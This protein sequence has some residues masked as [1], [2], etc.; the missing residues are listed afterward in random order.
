MVD[1]YF[2]VKVNRISPEFPMPIMTGNTGTPV[3]RPGG[4]ANVAYQFRHFNVDPI[5]F[6]FWDKYATDV[7]KSHDIKVDSAWGTQCC[8]PIKRR[9]LDGPVQITRHDIE[10]ELCGYTSHEAEDNLSNFKSA[11]LGQPKPHVAI[12]SDYNKGFFRFPAITARFLDYYRDTITIVDP[13]KGP[14]EQWQG[15]TIFKPNAKEAFELS[16][17]SNWRDQSRFFRNELGCEAVVITFGGERVAG[18]CKDELFEYRPVRPV[19]VESVIGA[20][21]CFAA[22]FAMA[23]GHGFRI[24]EAAEIAWNAGAVYVQA[25]MNRPIIPAE[26]AWDGIVYPEELASRDFRLVFTNGCFDLLH[27][28]HLNT[29]RFAKSKGD[30]LVV[31]LNSDESIK[32]L[33]GEDRPIKP[34][35]Q[36][37]AVMAALDMVDFVVSFDED[38]PKEVIDTILPDVL[39]KGGDWEPGTIVGADVVPEVFR[40]PVMEGLSTTHFVEQIENGDR[41]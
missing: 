5:L 13:K 26:V 1:E 35:E 37:M 15:C 17:M 24:S 27:E 20:G 19:H 3:R 31:A 21:D 25:N 18:L 34:L 7:F 41:Q 11:I 10:T 40:A 22:F 9:F 32:R 6:C 4:S 2:R 28:G 14:L 38:T 8:L 33:K 12:L 36:R 30:K 39:V 23:V 16:G 29:L